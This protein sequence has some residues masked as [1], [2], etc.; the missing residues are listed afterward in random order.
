MK[1]KQSGQ[2]VT[3][4]AVALMVFV[5]LVLFIVII[6]NML[7]VQTTAHKAARYMA[8]ER[9]AYTQAD[10]DSKIN[11]AT[12]SFDQE[13]SSRFLESNG[14]GFGGS[15][16]GLSRTWRNPKNGDSLVDVQLGAAVDTASYTQA[17]SEAENFLSTNGG[18]LADVDTNGGL[19]VDTISPAQLSIPFSVSNELLTG[20]NSPEARSSFA[21]LADGWAPASEQQYSDQ[22]EA[23][24][25]GTLDL[26]H[27]TIVG[28]AMSAFGVFREIPL[29]LFN[30]SDPF[31]MVS[32][33]QSTALPSNLPIYVEE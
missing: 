6:A 7:H 30:G 13:I 25:S 21:L 24:R 16:S 10:Y 23:M 20:D 22:V 5:P 4:F 2:A 14:A 33:N 19:S 31:N 8:W 3:E 9:V 18:Q 15:S 27:R 12:D 1:L 17:Q 28:G 29:R 32:P 26:A 11:S